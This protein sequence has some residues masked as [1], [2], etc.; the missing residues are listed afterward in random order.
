LK[1]HLQ[2]SGFFK[3][4]SC[5]VKDSGHVLQFSEKI[6]KFYFRSPEKDRLE[7]AGISQQV[8]NEAI[9]QFILEIIVEHGKFAERLCNKDPFTMK[10]IK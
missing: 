3:L 6:S 10:S 4:A 8:I 1:E 9:A 5:L 7:K 2:P